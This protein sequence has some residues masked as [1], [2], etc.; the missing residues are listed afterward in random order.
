MKPLLVFGLFFGVLFMMEK[1]YE[2]GVK[3]GIYQCR[4]NEVDC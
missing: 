3:H 4:I 2:D 1:S